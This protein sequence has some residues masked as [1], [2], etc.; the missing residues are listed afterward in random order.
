MKIVAKFFLKLLV[1]FTIIL[2]S[3]QLPASLSSS[4]GNYSACSKQFHCGNIKN[5]SYP[6]WGG[7][8]PENC[9]QP[10]L[11]LTCLENEETLISIVSVTYRVIEINLD[12]Q[13][14]TVA[15]TDLQTLCPQTLSNTT[16]NFNILSYAWNLENITLYYDCPLIS[17]IFLGFPT[18][19]NCSN[20]SGRELVNY[21]VIAS[22][23]DN[24]SD[25]VK[26][27]LQLRRLR[28]NQLQI[29][30]FCHSVMDLV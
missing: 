9:G 23:F 29:L 7:D 3:V 27:G 13:A 17:D 28:A 6:F 22:V 2:L 18:R 14:F 26:D 30:W 1:F 11:K 19:F 4:N 16:S 12:L 20:S 24:L 25:E 10:E 8:R 5:V 21:Y 15:R